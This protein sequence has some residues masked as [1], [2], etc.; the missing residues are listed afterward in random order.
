MNATSHTEDLKSSRTI[1]TSSRARRLLLAGMGFVVFEALFIWLLGDKIYEFSYFSTPL[2]GLLALAGAGY[3]ALGYFSR[4]WLSGL[5]LAAPLL[6]AVYFVNGVWTVE[7]EN[8][9]VI[10]TNANFAEIWLTLSFIF[11]PAW[12]LGVLS[13]SMRS[14]QS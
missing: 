4:S 11:V 7:Y 8:G 2:W 1:G 14:R 3:F 5:M 6:V 9:V 12:A 13:A 10:G